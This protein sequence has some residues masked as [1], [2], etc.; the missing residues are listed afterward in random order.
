[1][2]SETD[3]DDDDFGGSAG[4]AGVPAGEYLPSDDA[5]LDAALAAAAAHHTP[6]RFGIVAPPAAAAEASLDAGDDDLCRPVPAVDES[7]FAD[8]SRS[9]NLSDDTSHLFSASMDE[10]DVDPDAGRR[11][12]IRFAR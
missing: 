2:L 6:E 7:T 5:E 9:M 8:A 4:G 12:R 11:G 3:D 1:M 10:V